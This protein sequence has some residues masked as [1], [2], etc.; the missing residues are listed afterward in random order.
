MDIEYVEL[1]LWAFWMT[2]SWGSPAVSESSCQ[3]KILL[4]SC[5]TIHQDRAS[6]KKSIL[7]PCT[8]WSC[9]NN[10]YVLDVRTRAHCFGRNGSL[11]FRQTTGHAHCWCFAIPLYFL[12]TKNSYTKWVQ[13][14]SYKTKCMWWAASLNEEHSRSASNYSVYGLIRGWERAIYS[15]LF[16]WTIWKFTSKNQKSPRKRV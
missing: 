2:L 5:W 6:A 8:L 4:I 15:W 10:L 12:F 3:G 16:T 9:C 1:L 7:R 14:T 13:S 11:D